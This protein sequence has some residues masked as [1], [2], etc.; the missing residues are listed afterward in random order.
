MR[1]L[2]LEVSSPD[3]EQVIEPTPPV[4]DNWGVVFWVIPVIP[5]PAMAEAA[6]TVIAWEPVWVPVV[7]VAVRSTVSASNKVTLRMFGPST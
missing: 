4:H 6:F 2:L 5:M 7:K 3:E 1:T